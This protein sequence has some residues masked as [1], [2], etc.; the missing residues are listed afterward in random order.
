M[1]T[2]CCRRALALALC[3]PKREPSAWR[4][5]CRL[6]ARRAPSIFSALKPPSR[7]PCQTARAASVRRGAP[8]CERFPLLPTGTCGFMLIAVRVLGEGSVSQARIL[9]GLITEAGFIGGGAILKHAKRSS[10]TAT[11]A[12]EARMRSEVLGYGPTTLRRPDCYDLRRPAVDAGLEMKE[13]VPDPTTRDGR[14]DSHAAGQHQ[15]TVGL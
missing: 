15:R 10:G 8:V 2:T 3:C 7:S 14:I 13:T 12:A 1:A 9:E 11:V 6:A 4:D 5:S